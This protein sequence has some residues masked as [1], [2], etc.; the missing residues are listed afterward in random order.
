[1]WKWNALKGER[2]FL[3]FWIIL[4]LNKFVKN[5]FGVLRL[6]DGMQMC[7]E[8]WIIASRDGKLGWIWFDRTIAK[9]IHQTNAE[10]SH[11]RD[12]NE[13]PAICVITTVL[14]PSL[15][16]QIISQIYLRAFLFS[17]LPKLSTNIQSPFGNKDRIN[18]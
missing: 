4:C 8:K 6:S 1:M 17:F 3:V 9:R 18:N 10:I 13:I 14:I 12:E 11:F 7:L 2:K 5:F 15:N 16:S